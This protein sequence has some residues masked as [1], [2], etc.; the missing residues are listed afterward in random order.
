MGQC[1][2]SGTIPLSLTQQLDEFGQP[3]NGGKLYIIQ[4]GTVSTPQDSFQD[5][6]LSI[7]LPNPITMDAAG[8][9]PQFF[10]ADAAN[11]ASG[12]I[13]IRMTDS[14]GIVQREADQI[15][16]VGPSGG[17][18]GGGTPV[19]QNALIQYG[20]IVARYGVGLF[21][22]YVRLNGNSIGNV[23]SGSSE[24][25]NAD[26]QNLWIYLYGVDA[27]LTVSGGR[28]GNALNDYNA[29]K[30]LSLPDWRGYAL[31]ALDGMGAAAL[32][33]RL[34]SSY[35]G[36]AN[37]DALGA[38]GGG[39]NFTLAVAQLPNAAPTGSVAS[40][41]SG[42]VAIPVRNYVNSGSSVVTQLSLASNIGTDAGLLSVVPTGAV[43]STLTMNAL[44]SGQPH[45]TIGPRKLCTF[46]M[47]L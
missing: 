18:G 33:G 46:Y 45:R 23:T 16:V 36:A 25:S 11:G 5:P 20:N 22:G 2:M 37:P 9:L 21:T 1:L 35:F 32:A 14:A 13:K 34:T 26:T 41:F 38:V 8:R 24:R 7:K 19:D 42:N 4:A 17:S 12:F 3:L 30:Q 39:E 40:T 31:G 6:A 47:K 43:T 27:S 10:I 29:S 44:G 28:T 15:Q